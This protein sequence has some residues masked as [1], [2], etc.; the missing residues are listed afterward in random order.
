MQQWNVWME[1]VGSALVDAGALIW[2][3][4][5]VNDAGKDVAP[6][7]LTGYSIVE[8][9]DINA[10]KAYTDGHPFLTEGKGRFAI[11]IFELAQM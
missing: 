5:A 10:A 9:K 3:G 8:A 11:E 1:K 2:S 4:A 6:S 7:A